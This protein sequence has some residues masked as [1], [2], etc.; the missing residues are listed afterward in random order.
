MYYAATYYERQY[1]EDDA[2]NPYATNLRAWADTLITGIVDGTIDLIDEPGQISPA[3]ASVAFYPT[4]RSSS[5]EPTP[6]DRSLG[7]EVFSM[8]VVF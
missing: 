6:E 2:G 1:S 4:D 8:G 3:N 5:M 7:P